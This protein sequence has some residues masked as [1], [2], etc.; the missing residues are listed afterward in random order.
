[1][2]S[3]ICWS[4]L[5]SVK[6]IHL[7][8]SYQGRRLFEFRL[9]LVIKYWLKI[10]DLSWLWRVL[11]SATWYGVICYRGTTFS[12]KLTVH[13][14]SINISY[15]MEA[16]IFAGNFGNFLPKYLPSFRPRKFRQVF[17]KHLKKSVH[18]ATHFHFSK[19]RSAFQSH[20]FF[21]LLILYEI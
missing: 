1:M 17:S 2:C 15:K 9:S 12:E 13:V 18:Q 8:V 14:L 4:R 5:I 21:F 20:I 19:G 10:S 11:F 3:A 16:I 6:I 7:T